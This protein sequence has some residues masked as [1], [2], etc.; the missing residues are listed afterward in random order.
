MNAAV[1]HL[2]ADPNTGEPLTVN[3]SHAVLQ[4][5]Q[6]GRQFELK[7]GIALLLPDSMPATQPAADQLH[8]GYAT[9]FDYI[10]HYAKDGNYFDYFKPHESAV[11]KDEIRR[12]EEV[13]IDNIP[14][15][16]S[17]ILD[18]GCGNGWVAKHFC[19]KGKTVLSMDISLTNVTKVHNAV[20][21]D[22]HTGVIADVYHL[23]FKQN[24]IECI[25]AAEIIEHLVDPALFIAKI[26]EVLK[27][28]GTA[29]ITTPYNEKIEYYMCVYCNRPTPKNAHLHSFDFKKAAAIIPAERCSYTLS[30]F[31]NNY[32]IKL[33]SYVLL[34][35][36]PYTFW[37]IIDRFFN[38][39]FKTPTRLLLVIEKK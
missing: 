29:V 38:T 8:A 28:G 27:P 32:L 34:K 21:S 36:L 6:S 9:T 18:T 20:N 31:N 22:L 3:S 16:V 2:F 17:V 26:L 25:I 14:P 5:K 19:K 30:V 15:R 39:L 4:N 37:K 24:S 1:Q 35:Y 23:P 13:I 10:D 7:N 33:R 12:L 11:T